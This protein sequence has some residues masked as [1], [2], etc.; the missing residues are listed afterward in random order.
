M[1][2]PP[3]FSPSTINMTYEQQTPG[4]YYVDFTLNALDYSWKNGDPKP[5]FSN[6]P[7]WLTIVLTEPKR[8]H[9]FYYRAILDPTK[10]NLVEPK[11]YNFDVNVKLEF[12]VG[13]VN[14]KIPFSV[15]II[16]STPLDITPTQFNFAYTI[17]GTLPL[18][19]YLAVT[20]KINWQLEKDASWVVVNKTY[21]SGSTTV[22]ISTDPSGLSA[23]VYTGNILIKD[24]RTSKTVTVSLNVKGED[25]S[26]E[27]LLITPDA[28]EIIENY[29][30]LPK[31]T[32][33]V[34][35]NTS[36][37]ADITSNVNWLSFSSSFVSSGDNSLTVTI[38]DTE[39]LDKGIF[40]GKIFIATAFETKI[41]RVLLTINDTV[42][43]GIVSDEFY[44]ADDRNKIVMLNNIPNSDLLLEFEPYAQESYKKKVPFFRGLASSVLGEEVKNLIVENE[45]LNR[46][47]TRCFN[48]VS[49]VKFKIIAYDKQK[50]STQQTL[51]ETL[52]DVEFLTGATPLKDNFLSYIPEEITAVAD[53]L[54]CFSFRATEVVDQ[55]RIYGSVVINYAVQTTLTNIVTCWVNLA[56]LTLIEDDVI[57]ISCGGHNVQVTIKATEPKHTNI[58]WLNEWNTPETMTFTGYL[59]ISKP[60]EIQKTTYAIDGKEKTVVI[61]VKKPQDYTVST[62]VIYT[63]EERLFLS[64]I[65]DAKKIWLQ[66]DGEFVPVICN[67]KSL[68][69]SET[70]TYLHSYTLDF[71]KAI[72]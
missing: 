5:Q 22:E 3:I 67:T 49:T 68:I 58:V 63:P 1:A 62:G 50:I 53:G 26:N 45:F 2:L 17:G 60:S 48:P 35:I 56:E 12:L 24:G 25:Q 39:A 40:E 30:Q 46:T 18:K 33:T 51:R 66:I 61:D 42:I 37:R 15:Y 13:F 28:F 10:A 69:I 71:S 34:N 20:S 38:V 27:F 36:H 6:L 23:G 55:I 29:Q 32:K 47:T 64:S 8:D 72:I 11:T 52:T 44:Y 7:N 54:V 43:S 70:R 14:T 9:F 41:V 21:A 16:G 4:S 31:G 59:K 19:Q 65:L 57:V